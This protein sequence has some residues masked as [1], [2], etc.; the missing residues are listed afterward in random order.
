MSALFLYDLT[1]QQCIFWFLSFILLLF[2]SVAMLDWWAELFVVF[3]DFSKSRLYMSEIPGVFHGLLPVALTSCSLFMSICEIE[4][5]WKC[6][7]LDSSFHHCAFTSV[8]ASV[9]N[10]C[11]SC[12]MSGW[13]VSALITLSSLWW[14]FGSLWA[15]H[16]GWKWLSSLRLPSTARDGRQGFS[17]QS[18][19]SCSKSQA[20]A[21]VQFVLN[22]LQREGTSSV[23]RGKMGWKDKGVCCRK[24]KPA[25]SN[26]LEG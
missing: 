20:A 23:S 4:K 14:C 18:A 6:W 17:P 12:G 7:L 2:S 13:T 15:E 3:L 8:T 25:Y 10:W 22:I 9:Y 19:W 16:A 24:L 26:F 5:Q 1:K 21:A 11:C